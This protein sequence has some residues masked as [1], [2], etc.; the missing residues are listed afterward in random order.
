MPGNSCPPEVDV[1]TVGERIELM[2]RGKSIME[3]IPG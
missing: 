2:G 1:S 3:R